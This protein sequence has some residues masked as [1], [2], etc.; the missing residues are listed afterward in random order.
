M[1]R[2][3]RSVVNSRFF[4]SSR[5]NRKDLFPQLG[6]ENRKGLF[7]RLSRENRKVEH[8]LAGVLAKF[9]AGWNFAISV[10]RYEK[11]DGCLYAQNHRH[12]TRDA[13]RIIAYVRASRR[14]HI[15]GCRNVWRNYTAG[16]HAHNHVKRDTDRTRARAL[17]A[18]CVG[19][20]DLN[21]Y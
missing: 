5:E 3:C 11:I 18:V 20:G 12:A 8:T 2:T 1:Q 9:R 17:H 15:D 6:W 16:R 19:V 10:R 13:E 4:Q 14:R 21:R 7:S